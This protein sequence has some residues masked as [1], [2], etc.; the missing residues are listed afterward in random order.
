MKNNQKQIR[1][2]TSNLNSEFK[3]PL[4][5]ARACAKEPTTVATD[6]NK[7]HGHG[8]R[9]TKK[10]TSFP[11]QSRCSSKTSNAF[12]KSENHNTIAKH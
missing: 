2:A 6:S 9:A 4:A 8:T 3:R 5:A 10:Q 7:L 12:S 11:Q 1:R